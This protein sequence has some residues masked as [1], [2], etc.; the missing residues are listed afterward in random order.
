MSAS[1]RVHDDVRLQV[2]ES[3]Q[4]LARR[5]APRMALSRD[6]NSRG[7]AT[8]LSRLEFARAGRTFR[9]L[10]ELTGTNQESVRRY[11]RFGQP[12]LDYILRLCE[13]LELA[14]NWLMLG[15]GAPPIHD[16]RNRLLADATA[17]ELLHALGN[18]FERK[19]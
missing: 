18:V 13:A 11:H 6:D 12:S 2:R 15:K 1:L 14:P 19:E 8:L 10:S 7:Q 5:S 4:G 17:P 3:A 9:E 16:P